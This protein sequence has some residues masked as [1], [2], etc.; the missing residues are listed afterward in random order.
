M[1]TTRKNPV[2]FDHAKH[3]I[4][5]YKWFEEKA[6]YPE[7]AE[8]KM[9]SDYMKTFPNYTIIVRKDIKKNTKQEHYKGLTYEYMETYIRK[10]EPIE[11]RDSVLNEL[12]D[13]I[14]I[15]ECHSTGHRYPEIKKWFLKKYPEIANGGKTFI[16]ATQEDSTNT[17]EEPELEVAA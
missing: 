14:F 2:R 13:R 5:L 7:N 11:T 6:R 8:Y 17:S 10:Y 3:E 16:N 12:E 15:S 1:A 4:I 9:L